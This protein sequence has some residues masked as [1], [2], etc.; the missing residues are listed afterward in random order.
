[1]MARATMPSL[2]YEE[3]EPPPRI[4]VIEMLI[5]SGAYS[6]WRQGNPINLDEYCT[7]LEANLDWIWRYVALDVINPGNPNVAASESYNNYLAM[8]NRGL[9]PIPVF[10]VGED[11][12][13]LHRLVDAGADYIGLSASSIGS[14]VQIDDWYAM[15]FDHL[16]DKAGLPIVKT[17]AFGEGRESCLSRF[18]WYSADSSSWLY[19]AQRSAVIR[20]ANGQKVSC[21]TDGAS[22]ISM[23]DISTLNA[24]DAQA[25]D[26]IFAAGGIDRAAFNE[27]GMTP[28]I[29]S[30]YSAALYFKGIENRVAKLCPIKHTPQGFFAPAPQTAPA[31]AIPRPRVFLVAGSN[32]IAYGIFAKQNLRHMLSSYFDIRGSKAQRKAGIPGRPHFALLRDMAFDPLAT[33]QRVDPTNPAPNQYYEILCKYVK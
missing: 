25:L 26:E 23:Q 20:L 31:I 27:K 11:I 5:D 6:A 21:R 17:H 14:R 8:R 30:S 4:P 12:S 19:A 22:S 7:F 24:H 10:H 1:M 18:P 3:E 33:V 13:W 32:S 9:S 2:F 29:V 16:T 28:Y 15:C